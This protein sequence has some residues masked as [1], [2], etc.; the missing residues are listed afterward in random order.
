MSSTTSPESHDEHA[1]F[2]ILDV[3]TPLLRDGENWREAFKIVSPQV[4]AMLGVKRIALFH[5]ERYVPNGM[6]ELQ[7]AADGVPE[8]E[9]PLMLADHLPDTA[10]AELAAGKSVCSRGAE[11]FG[12][13]PMLD[14]RAST[15]VPVFVSGRWWGTLLFG[16][17][18]GVQ[19]EKAVLSGFAN[20]IGARVEHE[21]L[22]DLNELII[23]KT[24]DGFWDYDVLE[25]KLYYSDRYLD[26][27]GLSREEFGG[28]L[29]A[30]IR[31]LHPDELDL[32]WDTYANEIEA[33]DSVEIENRIRDNRSG[34]YRNCVSRSVVQRDRYGNVVRTAGVVHD[35]TAHRRLGD[36]RAQLA[37]DL[38]DTLIQEIATAGIYAD[39]SHRLLDDN[40]EEAAV[41]LDHLSGQLSRVADD[42]R[43][44]VDNLRGE[45]SGMVKTIDVQT[46]D[47]VGDFE[48]HSPGVKVEA[49]IDVQ[50]G[51]ALRPSV[52]DSYGFA[53]RELLSNVTRHAK[54]EHLLVSLL[55]T[56]E[57]LVLQVVDDG[58]GFDP[59]ELSID[60]RFGIIGLRERVKLIGGTI[61]WQPESNGGTNVRVE[62]PQPTGAPLSD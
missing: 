11:L 18:S 6:I 55:V 21:Q 5:D 28:T 8:L 29:E 30:Y 10:A 23:N 33:Q 26:M 36:Y 34:G 51:A 52:L 43:V 16:F 50:T 42:L 37:R 2:V 7:W 38:H 31:L 59:D 19:A 41:F 39:M 24:N 58:V 1:P 57:H 61:E 60:G 32:V 25:D 54:A 20:L 44:L 47:L 13:C 12:G 17:V 40:R 9:V 56:E 49:F 62:V 27:I 14:D 4:A 35:V 45:S 53:L 3:L 22:R 46:A 15:L 48:A